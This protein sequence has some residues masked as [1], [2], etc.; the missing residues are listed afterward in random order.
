MLIPKPV[1]INKTPYSE[2]NADK[3]QKLIDDTA[4]A[5]ALIVMYNAAPAVTFVVMHAAATAIRTAQNTYD[6]APIPGNLQLIENARVAGVT[7]LDAQAAGVYLIANDT[8]NCPAGTR[9]NAKANILIAL[10]AAEKLVKVQKGTPVKPQ[11]KTS[12]AGVGAIFVDIINA[13]YQATRTTYIIAD[14]GLQIQV[15]NGQV[16]CTFTQQ[17]LLQLQQES[18]S[19]GSNPP[20][21]TQPKTVVVRTVTGK[22][23]VKIS[24]LGST[25][26]VNVSCFGENR[27]EVVGERSDEHPITVT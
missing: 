11:I 5:M 6:L 13:E 22:K 26:K 4:N 21:D 2:L 10:F 27:K 18:G 9:E 16:S 3:L 23:R 15:L 14:L 8:A 7:L 1:H 25:K 19:G 17:S 24:N 20:V 12:N